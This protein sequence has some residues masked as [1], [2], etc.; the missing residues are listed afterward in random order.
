MGQQCCRQNID[1]SSEIKKEENEVEQINFE[2]TEVNPME[3]NPGIAQGAENEAIAL[4]LKSSGTGSNEENDGAQAQENENEKEP[5][6][7]SPEKRQSLENEQENEQGNTDENGVFNPLTYLSQME[8]LNESQRR[9]LLGLLQSLDQEM[10]KEYLDTILKFTPDKQR[11]YLEQLI[12]QRRDYIN[13]LNPHQRQ[14]YLL[15]LQQ[16]EQQLNNYLE[17]LHQLSN[18]NSL[19]SAHKS[20]P[21]EVQDEPYEY[22]KNSQI[23]LKQGNS[24]EQQALVQGDNFVNQNIPLT[25]ETNPLLIQI[26]AR[27]ASL[28]SASATSQ[29]SPEGFTVQQVG[30]DGMPLIQGMQGTQEVQQFGGIP[31]I[32][33]LQDIQNVNAP[34]I[35]DFQNFGNVQEIQGQGIQDIQG[36]QVIQP[37]QGVQSN[38]SPQGY[39]NPSEIQAEAKQLGYLSAESQYTFATGNEE[40][41]MRGSKVMPSDIRDIHQIQPNEQEIAELLMQGVTGYDTMNQQYYVQ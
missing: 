8:G 13:S 36:I 32:G 2:A 10:Q 3:S 15:D 37:I 34:Q 23:N 14:A 30:I 40:S 18:R 21:Q 27:Q 6:D 12:E 39:I 16:K 17:Q 22:N 41:N 9:Q 20:Q 25:N 26:E 7:E 29:M 33:G 11:L 1:A 35:Q 24:L 28:N 19:D 31:E 5:V 4:K 38:A